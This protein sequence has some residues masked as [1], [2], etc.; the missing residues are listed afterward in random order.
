MTKESMK[1]Y[2]L[3]LAALEEHY[4][5]IYKIISQMDNSPDTRAI[6]VRA[7][8][9]FPD[10]MLES[11]SNKIFCYG[12]DDPM[13]YCRGYIESLDLHY[14]PVLVFLGFGLGYQVAVTLNDFAKKLDIQHI[15]IV[16]KDIKL[17][18][19]ALMTLDFTG[20]IRH[21]NIEIVLGV[22]SDKLVKTFGEYFKIIPETANFFKSLKIVIMPSVQLVDF[23][24]YQKAFE[25]LKLSV[26]LELQYVGN[27]PYDSILGLRQTLSN[28]IPMIEDP[29]ILSFKDCMKGRPAIVIGAGP[30]LNKSMKFLKEASR[31]AFLVCVDAAL[32][33]LL[34]SGVR[35]HMVTNIERTIGQDAFFSSLGRLDDIFFVFCPLVPSETCEA[36]D[37]PKIIAHRYQEM[38]D[39]LELQT[40]ALHGG[41]LVGNFAFSIAQHLGCDPIIMTGQD[42]SFPLTGDTHVDGMVFGAQEQYRS[43]MIEIEGY[44]GETL[45]TNRS[46]EESRRSLELDIEQQ[47][48]LCVN[49][50]EGGAKINGTIFLDLQ[51]AIKRYCHDSGDI[52]E[53]LRIIWAREKKKKEGGKKEELLKVRTILH[54]T[55]SNLEILL[56]S[57]KEGLNIVA[58]FE[59]KYDLSIKEKPNPAAVADIPEYDNKLFQ[60]REQI[61][62]NPELR[63]LTY[64]FS[65]YHV[66]FAMRRNFQFDRFNDRS[67]AL[68]KSFLME[69]EYFSIMGQLLLSTIYSI[70]DAQIELNKEM[71]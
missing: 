67:Y 37:G 28:V 48:S 27:D 34:D 17:F 6:D 7:D 1:T 43:N 25:S 29:G 64:I 40:G 45:L 55:V 20:M 5:D 53:F 69:K 3:N 11:Q 19:T 30:S 24:Y 26:M 31:K 63:F 10:L 61:I 4:P 22:D 66:D 16:E 68:L 38:N 70:K 42:L 60:I 18:Q 14:A 57:C 21:P 47:D 51:T 9:D 8:A 15:I 35:P 71:Y 12:G 2:H 56:N 58:D 52:R 36:Y 32:K 46:F 44:S 59:N 33:P 41:P 50:S 65:G 49:T 54:E 62:S 39:W 13:E 23:E